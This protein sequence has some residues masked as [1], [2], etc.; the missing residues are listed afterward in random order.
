M[1][2]ER[3]FDRTSAYYDDWVRQAIPGY[4][5]VF[6]TAVELVPFPADA[7]LRVLDLGAGTGLF[8]ELVLRSYSR[9]HFVLYDLAAELLALAEQRFASQAERFRYVRGDYTELRDAEAYHLVISSLS[10]HH[11]E[12]E[13]KR[14]LF[15]A[16][17][18]ALV[19]GGAF[20]NVDQ[21]R[22]PTPALERLYWNDWLRKVR[23]AGAGEERIQDSVER[24]RTYDRD[25]SLGEQLD[26][27]RDAGF[28]DVDCVYKNYF[29]GVFFATKS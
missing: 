15:G 29:V 17:H 1:A 19:S 27:L 23:E 16:I 20:I 14:D 10:I 7:A 13:Q 11:L 8:S 12:H 3:A 22:A 5:A 9:A 25:A 28:E 26:W 21:I 4:D 2:I 18:R 6:R 24:R